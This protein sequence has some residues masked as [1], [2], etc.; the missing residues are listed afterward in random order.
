[1]QLLAS[2]KSSFSIFPVLKGLRVNLEQNITSLSKLVHLRLS[3]HQTQ[4]L[5]Y[6][7]VF[8]YY[9]LMRQIMNLTKCFRNFINRNFFSNFI[10]FI[11]HTI[12]IMSFYLFI[13]YPCFLYITYIF[14]NL[15]S[16][17]EKL[18]RKI[19]LPHVLLSRIFVCCG[20]IF[21]KIIN[22]AIM[23]SLNIFYTPKSI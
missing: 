12:F 17:T 18:S 20:N 13:F 22:H 21:F 1:M 16:H 4:H 5:G 8:S 3:T 7:L 11:F 15:C 2:Q 19:K 6:L 14:F 23:F 9:W 10:L